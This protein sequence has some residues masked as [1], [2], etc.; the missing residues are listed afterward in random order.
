MALQ[1][2]NLIPEAEVAG[3]GRSRYRT[4]S[5]I[6]GFVLAIFLAILLIIFVMFTLSAKSLHDIRV[7]KTPVEN[8]ID[9]L[10]KR[11]YYLR[12]IA[13][14]VGALQNI[15][16]AKPPYDQIVSR[17]IDLQ[18]SDVTYTELGLSGQNNVLI[19]GTAA[20][21]AALDRFLSDITAKEF[22]RQVFSGILLQ[23][24]NRNDGGSYAFT[25]HFT[26]NS[27]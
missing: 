6:S 24:L 2:V 1:E 22:G 12:A 8:D 15:E 4:I 5:L 9:Q 13:S 17:L 3:G 10:S 21:I 19:S 16:L 25:M 26:Y 11:E 20:N 18:S 14:K 23:S 27:K 7:E